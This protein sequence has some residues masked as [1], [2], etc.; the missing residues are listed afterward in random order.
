M[1]DKIESFEM[2]KIRLGKILQN[3]PKNYLDDG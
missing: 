3:T 2:V 1:N